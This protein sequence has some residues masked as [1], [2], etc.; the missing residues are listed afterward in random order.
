M[1]G[2]RNVT[3]ADTAVEKPELSEGAGGE[4]TRRD[5]SRGMD[6]GGCLTR[7]EVELERR[8][9]IG[10]SWIPHGGGWPHR[11]RRRR[12]QRRRGD[13]PERRAGRLL[14]GCS[15]R[16]E[17]QESNNQ[18]ANALHA[19]RLPWHVGLSTEVNYLQPVTALG[20]P[21][22]RRPERLTPHRIRVA[23][24]PQVQEGVLS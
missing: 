5:D 6:R 11:Q 19:E 8:A 2:L 17:Q 23:I 24:E 10:L 7:L 12:C 21:P 15:R 13:P 16:R 18:Q 22:F 1:D 20:H 3:Q 4:A 14:S 9:I